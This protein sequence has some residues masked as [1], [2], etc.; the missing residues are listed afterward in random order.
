MKLPVVT[1]PLTFY[2]CRTPVI[3]LISLIDLTAIV[4]LW[5]D[6]SENND[7]R[8]VVSEN[9]IKNVDLENLAIWH[10]P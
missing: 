8:S 10:L 3:P 1:M 6:V 4:V 5:D 2:W 7:Y 9:F